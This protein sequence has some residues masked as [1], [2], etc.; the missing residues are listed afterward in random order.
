[1]RKKPKS[2]FRHLPRYPQ[3]AESI[4]L[5]MPKILGLGCLTLVFGGAILLGFD[6]RSDRMTSRL[7]PQFS[8]NSSTSAV[9]AAP[10]SSIHSDRPGIDSRGK[11]IG[12]SVLQKF[13]ACGRIRANCVVDGDTFWL[14]GEKIRIADIDTPETHQPKC[15]TERELGPRATARL[16]GLLNEGPF[17]IRRLEG[18]DVDRYGRSLRLVV[19]DGVSI[20]DTLVDEGLAHRWLGGKVSWCK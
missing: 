14:A 2:K 7:S 11:K 16:M 19:R 4:G 13:N 12:V 3:Q 8:S 17:Q 20:A 6:S 9:V 5:S 10:P 15:A 1:M 18:R